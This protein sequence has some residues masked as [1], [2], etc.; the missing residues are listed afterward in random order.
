VRLNRPN[1]FPLGSAGRVII[2]AG[3]L[4]EPHSLPS[5]RALPDYAIARRQPVTLTRS[6]QSVKLTKKIK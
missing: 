2:P 3:D 4:H 1:D 5:H 6:R